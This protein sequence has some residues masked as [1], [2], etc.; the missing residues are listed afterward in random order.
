[1]VKD[2]RKD[3]GGMDVKVLAERLR[4]DWWSMDGRYKIDLVIVLFS[5]FSLIF[6]VG[7]SRPLVIAP[8]ENF[9]TTDSKIL[10]SIEKASKL[11]IDDN[12]Q[13]TTPEEYE[14]YDG[15][16]ID[17]EPGTYDWNDDCFECVCFGNYSR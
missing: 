7:Y 11:V 5:V 6:L 8:I 4:S 17:L 10:F 2:K 12:P 15:M 9:E 14:V 16:K 1:M 3:K 13:F